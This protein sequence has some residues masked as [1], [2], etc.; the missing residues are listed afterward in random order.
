MSCKK[1]LILAL[2]SVNL[3]SLRPH[4][5]SGRMP[6]LRR[7]IAGGVSG[8]LH[9]TV[10]A[11]TAAAWTTLSTGKHPGIHGVMNF[12]RFDPRAQQTRL[13]ATGD[14]PHKTVWQLLDEAG[15][16]AGVVGQ[17]QSY[18]A[19]ELKHGFAVTGFE[20][21]S[22]DCE[23]TWPPAL[24]QEV[25]Q[26]VPG[27]CFKSE[28][29]RDPGAGKDWAHWPDFSAGMD[30]LSE[31][32]ERA[33]ALNLF[34][35]T[36]RPWDVL[37]LYY[38]ATD[39]LFHKAW[40][41]CDPQTRDE[42]RERAARIDGFF[43][44]LDEM[45]GQVAALPQAAGA[46]V[47]CC[48][49][50]GHGPVQELVRVNGV[51]ADLGYL[52]RGGLMTQARDAWRRATGQRRGKGM[53]IAVDW[54]G[55][56]AYMPFEAI[57]GFVYLNRAGREPH[58]CVGDGEAAGLVSELAANLSKQT[59]PHS[60]RPLF[61]AV[62]PVEEVYPQRGAFDF[63]ELFA[64]PARGVNFVRKLSYGPAVE[65]PEDKYKGT[66]RPE[67]FF[68]LHGAGVTAGRSAEAS[69]GDIA[70]TLLAALGLPVPSD[71]T[72]RVLGDFFSG[73]LSAAASAP[74]SLLAQ[75]GGDAYS[76]AEKALVEQRLADLGYV[77]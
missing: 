27:F 16:Q 64:L 56:R 40:R 43:A 60:G 75:G 5:D 10:P 72:G 61:D 49:D 77:D 67:G 58:G 26:R 20:T 30:S 74:S 66:H 47:V 45:L 19:R 25:L 63:P 50:H 9:S 59:S 65:I 3:E 29:V 28:R 37:F 70:P 57:A 18:P 54:S 24:K 23:F 8:V 34:L 17:P 68:A 4:L 73:G 12:R 7:L 53:G 33:H 36:S 55:T 11:H 46:L 2:D 52:K 6:N 38:Q 41:W 44:R 32:N 13:N 22:T 35:A 71:M 15:L 42:D 31:E 48:S 39:P 1:V 14:V 51:L 69:I 21:P 62:R 76:D